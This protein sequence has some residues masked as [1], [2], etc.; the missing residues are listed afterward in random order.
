[1]LLRKKRPS[2]VCVIGNSHITALKRHWDN[3]PHKK[4][5]T[6]TFFGTSSIALKGLRV[7]GEILTPPSKASMA[8]FERTSGGMMK[9][10][11]TQFDEFYLHG[12]ISG[13]AL[14]KMIFDID[15]SSER[16]MALSSAFTEEIITTFYD[17][18][19]LKLVALK[20]RAATDKPIFVSSGPLPSTDY[21]HSRG[22]I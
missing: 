11:C 6:P 20:L 10:D 21:Q 2:K 8:S 15:T 14:A 18:S 3:D 4:Q 12:M 9:I 1:M 17:E 16:G 22:A 5:W 7:E 13:S 19:L